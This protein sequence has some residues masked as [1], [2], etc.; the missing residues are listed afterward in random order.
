MVILYDFYQKVTEQE[1]Q[2]LWNFE[3]T[4]ESLNFG[5][6]SK[7]CKIIFVPVMTKIPF[8]VGGYLKRL[9]AVKKCF[10]TSKIK[11]SDTEASTLPP[12]STTPSATKMLCKQIKSMMKNI[13]EKIIMKSRTPI[14]NQIY[15][16]FCKSEN[17]N[18]GP[19]RG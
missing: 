18:W 9:K 17:E 6:G 16:V 7:I 2:I 1:K 12:S 4:L 8:S 14:N 13:P 3:D 15:N 19:P 10:S 5:T 11:E